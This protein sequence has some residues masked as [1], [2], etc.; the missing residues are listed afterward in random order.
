MLK[1]CFFNRLMEPNLQK[2]YILVIIFWLQSEQT[3]AESLAAFISFLMFS[4]Y[5]LG[6]IRRFAFCS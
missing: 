5:T 4:S 1:I 2:A 3:G 6:E